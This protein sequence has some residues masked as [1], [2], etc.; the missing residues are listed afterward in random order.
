LLATIAV[1]VYRR[2]RHPVL[3]MLS[4]FDDWFSLLELPP[5]YR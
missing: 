5:E 3:R 2:L 4:N 1:T